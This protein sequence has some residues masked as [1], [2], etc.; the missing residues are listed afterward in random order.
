MNM[1]HKINTATFYSSI[2]YTAASRSQLALLHL[3]N[4]EIFCHWQTLQLRENLQWCTGSI[5]LLENQY[6]VCQNFDYVYITN[7]NFRIV[8]YIFTIIY[9]KTPWP[10]SSSELHRPS[11]RHLS[12]KLVPT[13]ADRR[14]KVVSVTDPYGHILGFLDRS[15]YFFFQVAPH[16]YSRGWVD[17]VPDPLLLR[18]SDSAGHRTRSSGSVARNSDH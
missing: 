2:Y 6:C 3:C 1:K 15:R 7:I 5:S 18:K 8:P 4:Y 17:H 11:D 10:E 13:F 14:S 9:K 16:L 12:V